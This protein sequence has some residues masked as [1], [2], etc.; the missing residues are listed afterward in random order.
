V[1]PALRN[2][3]LI[4]IAAKSAG[5]SYAFGRRLT[6]VRVLHKRIHFKTVRPVAGSAPGMRLVPLDVAT[7]ATAMNQS[8]HFSKLDFRAHRPRM[9]AH[10]PSERLTALRKAEAVERPTIAPLPVKEGRVLK[11]GQMCRFSMD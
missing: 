1:L 4:P 6:T 11:R 2:V 9:L 8:A 7:Q 3:A 10:G 5:R